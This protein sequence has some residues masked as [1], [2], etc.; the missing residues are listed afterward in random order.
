MT[1]SQFTRRNALRV[2]SGALLTGVAARK[3][4]AYVETPWSVF[5][6]PD[7]QYLV[8]SG[9]CSN[10]PAEMTALVNWEIANRNLVIGGSPINSKAVLSS[11]DCVN[12]ATATAYEYQGVLAGN[13]AASLWGGGLGYFPVCGNHD[14]VAGGAAF[15]RGKTIGNLT[16][17]SNTDALWRTGAFSASNL[18]SVYGSGLA[19]GSGDKAY[20]GGAYTEPDSS[21]TGVNSWYWMQI[22]F[23]RI[24][25]LVLEFHPREA[26]LI[27]AKSVH[28]ANLDKEFWICTHAYLYNFLNTS[29]DPQNPNNRCTRGITYGPNYYDNGGTDSFGTADGPLSYCGAGAW[30]GLQTVAMPL[31]LKD[32]SNLTLI[33]NG[34]FLTSATANSWWWAQNNPRSSSLRQQHVTEM[35][36]NLQELDNTNQCALDGTADTGHVVILR[37]M[38]GTGFQAYALSVNRYNGSNPCWIGQYGDANGYTNPSQHATPQLLFTSINEGLP[39][40]GGIS[41]GGLLGIGGKGGVQ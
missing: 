7:V 19:L 10:A 2:M 35:F 32:W 3:A 33:T 38:P 8:E 24:G 39:M 21:T 30:R 9:N 22:G 16:N 26:V 40:T 20:Y 25:V 37:Y 18:A 31:G 27:W 12:T 11:G 28:D 23:R 17:N 15:G 34:H 6:Q 29:G 41:E 14:Y 4:K 5:F 13:A 36:C 1:L